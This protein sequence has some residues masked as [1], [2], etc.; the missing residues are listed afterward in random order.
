MKKAPFLFIF[1]LAFG[2]LN[3]QQHYQY[4]TD[5]KSGLQLINSTA[6]GLSLHYA[7]TE[8]DIKT[9]NNSE[10]KGQEIIM[11]G[12]F[13]SF[14]EGLPNL[15]FENRYIAIPQGATIRFEINEKG[16]KTLNDIDL[17]PAAEVVENKAVGLPKLHK[18][19][20]VYGTDAHF[21]LKNVSIT[22]L[23]KIRGL[24]VALL[25]VTPFRYNPVQKTLEVIYDMDIKVRF[26]GGNGQFGEDRYRNP[27]WDNILRNLVINND[28]LPEQNY[29]ELL[30]KA[31]Q[32]KEEGCE[33][34]IITLNDSAFLAWAD[35]LKDFRTRQGILTKVITTD[36]CGGNKPE[37]IR[38]YIIN[39]YESWT[40][41]PAAVLLFGGN[42]KSSPEFGL[43]PFIFTSPPSWNHTYQYP[44]DN[45][46]ADMNG[47]SIPD[48]AI[49]RIPVYN[50]RNC[51]KQVGKLISYERHPSIESHYYDHPVITSG[52][53]EDKWFLIT[54]QSINHFL[55]KKHG[56]HSTNNYMV[57]SQNSVDLIPSD[58]IWS[59]AYNT[60]AVLNYFGPDGTQYIPSSIKELNDWCSSTDIQKLID[61]ISEEGFLTFY[62]DHSDMDTWCCPWFENR[63]VPLLQNK[64]P[65][66]LFS[67]GC[68]TNNFWDN[69]TTSLSE[70]FLNAEAGAIGAI[71]AN[72]VTYSHYNDLLTWGM[73]DYF[74]PDFM[75][76]LGSHTKPLFSHPS[77][78]LVAGKLFLSQ[79]T[80]LPYSLDTT[81]I[82]KTLNLFSY[83][84]DTYLQLNTETPQPMTVQACPYH[85]KRQSQYEFTIEEDAI[86]CISKDNTIIAV[87]QGIG[88]PQSIELPPL[89]IYDTLLLTVTKQN[90][91]PHEQTITIIPN[92]IP[93]VYL[94][95]HIFNDQNGNGKLEEGEYVT[96]DITLHHLND[97]PTSGASITLES[98]SPF[99]EILQNETSYPPLASN[100]TFNISK[101]FQIKLADSVPDNT[102]IQF[103]VNFNDDENQ[104]TDPIHAT[105]YSP[106]LT[107]NPKYR[108]SLTNDEP[109]THIIPDGTT[110]LTYQVTNK[111][112]ATSAPLNVSLNIKAPFIHI[113]EPHVMMEALAPGENKDISFFIQSDNEPR[114]AW[115]QSCID[116]QDRI[117]HHHI[118]TILQYNGIIENFETDT[119]NP[120]FIW[121]N[122]SP[123]PWIYCDDDSYEGSRCLRSSADNL[124]SSI[125]AKLR[126]PYVKHNCKI[127][128][129]YKN[130]NGY[131]NF[132]TNYNYTNQSTFIAEEWTY[133]EVLYNGM[134]Q[135]LTWIHYPA[136]SN[137]NHAKLDDICFPPEHRIIAHAGEDLLACSNDGV[138]LSDAY[139]Y[140]CDTVYW[141]SAGD[142]YFAHDTIVNTTYFPG[143]ED[144][145]QGIVTLTLHAMSGT[146]TVISSTTV[147]LWPEFE[148]GDII[149][150]SI[151][152][153]YKQP[154]SHYS[155][156][157]VEGSHYIWNLEPAKAGWIY[158]N[159][160]QVDILWNTQENFTTSTLS[161]ISDNGCE[162]TPT[163]LPIQLVGY[164]IQ[165]GPSM[166]I[167]LF[168]NPTDGK[169]HLVSGVTI[170]GKAYLEVFNLMG[171]CILFQTTNQLMQGEPLT[172]DLTSLRS[173]LY[174]IKLNTS[175]GIYLQKVNLR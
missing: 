11:K 55:C 139:A 78:S 167:K 153:I 124:Y 89:E 65:T 138:E 77:Y 29:Y 14:A 173:G 24:D 152:N 6:K 122:T 114:G 168:P 16:T 4:R 146:D 155:V 74:W 106:V 8:I 115:L 101:A 47:D 83:L 143:A 162:T 57:F 105:V 54:S 41:P 156:E 46:F 45:P 171:E 130:N 73:F 133:A 174:F 30:N 43:Q 86:L 39:A 27:A 141:T 5:T 145:Q 23:T 142:G 82:D 52:Y 129:Y 163:T 61:A 120:Y 100:D 169:I 102:S 166:D 67:I 132:Y 134:D 125:D 35:T 175:Q 13:G 113:E 88:Q 42:H 164:A 44:S 147:Q 22:K 85:K 53:E 112:H 121:I 3:A 109:S 72:S 68:L 144:I 38:N 137:S 59:S 116:M 21:P 33:Y 60:D 25:S 81:K 76:S 80:F 7:I 75:P 104:H 12:S 79:Q 148:I 96:L 94:K 1:C 99:V 160:N 90:R 149:G 51:Q 159:K 165:E 111:G 71:G 56:K 98:P 97:I 62:R 128:F 9:I 110:K 131:L 49:S 58:T 69:Y 107:I 136:S 127:S 19:M 66:F 26:E 123:K 157:A 151:V 161:V 154:I 108:L 28:M 135:K 92:D 118:D 20:S 48:L 50:A 18:D 34:L 103:H 87:I 140:D 37:N 158:A 40:I 91:I 119:L 17:L 63:H 10:V 95:D 2:F 150:D 64:E 84:G 15:P 32:N 31:I 70:E 117:Y 172:I 126:K 36:D 93:F 170:P